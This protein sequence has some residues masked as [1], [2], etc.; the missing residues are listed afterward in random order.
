MTMEAIADQGCFWCLP[1][2]KSGEKISGSARQ[3]KLG[4][5]VI[6]VSLIR[7]KVAKSPSFLCFWIFFPRPYDNS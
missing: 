1:P 4:R 6:R 2:F 5:T 3:C 7:K